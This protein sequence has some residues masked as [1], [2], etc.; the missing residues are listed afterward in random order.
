[1]DSRENDFAKAS[2]DFDASEMWPIFCGS[3]IFLAISLEG[4]H[5]F[6]TRRPFSRA[7]ILS[8]SITAGKLLAQVRSSGE[9]K[10][11]EERPE[12]AV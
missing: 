4:S 3:T 8:V 5:V 9:G 6:D 7:Y 10:R 2:T 12:K 11:L 1:M